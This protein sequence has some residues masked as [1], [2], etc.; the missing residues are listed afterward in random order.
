MA[1]SGRY[2]GTLTVAAVQGGGQRGFRA[3]D[4]D[5]ALVFDAHLD[6]SASVGAG[7]D[8]VLWPED[9]VDVDG[10]FA[11]SPE[12]QALSALAA[13]LRTTLVVG[14]TEDAGDDRFLNAS[15]AFGPDGR[16]VD[17]YDKVHR[18]PFGEY[19]PARSFFARLGD[20]SA[21]PRDAVAGTGPGVVDTPAGRFG[22]LISYEVFFQDRSR[23]AVR[24][25]GRLLLVPTNASSYVD[26]QV[27]AQQLAVARLRALETGRWVVQAAPTGYSAVVDHHGHV[28]ARSGLGGAAVLRH[29]VQ[30]RTGRTLFV[31]LGPAPVLLVAAAILAIAHWRP[32]GEA[33]GDSRA[34]AWL[35]FRAGQEGAPIDDFSV[36]VRVIGDAGDGHG[37]RRPRRG[38]RPRPPDSTSSP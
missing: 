10:V 34:P 13:E 21:V 25:G 29:E 19:I 18:V 1:P 24:A 8:V 30:L 14:I 12:E 2:N 36:H 5:P 4:S 3:V 20:V 37:R 38:G 22:V 33:A 27:P 9:V 31:S 17:R 16:V 32:Q 7:A 15:V 6:A 23:D 11:G 28:L 35:D 26:A